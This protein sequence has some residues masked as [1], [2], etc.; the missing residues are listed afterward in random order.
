MKKLRRSITW[1]KQTG[2][3]LLPSVFISLLLAA[4]TSVSGALPVQAATYYAECIPEG[5]GGITELIGSYGEPN[6]FA[7][8]SEYKDV[9]VTKA[10]T[11]GENLTVDGIYIDSSGNLHVDP[12]SPV[13]GWLITGEIVVPSGSYTLYG[14][15][16]V[17]SERHQVWI[18]NETRARWYDY[19]SGSGS[20]LYHIEN[21]P[22]AAIEQYGLY[23]IDRIEVLIWAQ[24]SVRVLCRI[25]GL[26][27][28]SPVQQVNGFTTYTLRDNLVT[29]TKWKFSE[30][31]DLQLGVRLSKSTCYHFKV[32]VVFNNVP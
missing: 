27:F 7:A 6:W 25:N 14:G 3:V 2:L 4:S 32:R 23:S 28:N 16:I 9:I 17:W 30:I 11:V 29:G 19:V 26:D 10:G 21:T 24:G 1:I 22:Q 18:Q 20:D 5:V 15:E 13:L 12:Q 31:S 8:S